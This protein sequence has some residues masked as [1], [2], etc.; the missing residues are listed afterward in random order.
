MQNS[1]QN[2]LPTPQ[3][4]KMIES[5]MELDRE[6]NDFSLFDLLIVAAENLKLLVL[7]SLVA[8]LMAL[9]VG[10]ILPQTFTSQAV[11][12]IPYPAST[13]TQTQAQAAAQAA[14]MMVSSVVLDS[15]IGASSLSPAQSRGAASRKLASQI[16]A[17]VG[18]DGLL[19]LDFTADTPASAQKL[20]D[21][22]IDAWL[23]STLPSLQDR[24]DLEVRLEYAKVSLESVRRLMDRI[25][26]DGPASLTK[27]VTRGDLSASV[28][29][30]GELQARYLGDTLTIPR[31][32]RGLTRDV[33]VQPPT[34]PTEATSPNKTSMAVLS[35]LA[36]GFALLLWV[37]VRQAW[38]TVAQDRQLLEKKSRLRKA[39]GFKAQSSRIC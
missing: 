11:L 28:V 30:F 38:K 22:V 23:K 15:I 20:A 16:K 19:R 36:C 4:I 5:Q 7:G 10:F 24:A 1:K 39:L 12:A 8:G 34:L 25:A 2:C 14:A 13:Q 26:V 6:E 21:A 17:V 31:L 9:S 32:L 33:V 35:A 27:P 29:A 18:K 3:P 37:F